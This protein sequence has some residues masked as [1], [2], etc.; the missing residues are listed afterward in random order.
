MKTKQ[1]K[2]KSCGKPFI[3]H[4]GIEGTCR[5]L[6]VATDALRSILTLAN[7][8]GATYAVKICKDALDEIGGKP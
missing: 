1:L 7:Q 5:N 8:G 4:L 6:I 2:C 3:K